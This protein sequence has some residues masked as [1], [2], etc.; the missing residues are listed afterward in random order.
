VVDGPRLYV[1]IADD[2]GLLV[3]DGEEG[4]SAWVTE[5]ELARRIDVLVAAGGSVLLSQ[6]R[7]S[8]AATPILV[9][10][11]AAGARIVEAS[12]PHPDTRR[13]DGV[14]ALMASAYVGAAELVDDVLRRG[15]DLEARDASGYTALMY[16]TNGGREAIVRALLDAGADVDAPD[17]RGS[18]PL[19][20][21]AQLGSTRVVEWLLGRGADAGARR[22]ADGLTALDVAERNGHDRAAAIL[23]S[24]T[25][26][27]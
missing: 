5:A 26:S 24:V 12:A 27:T 4:R 1:H 11:E 6:E 18:T 9:S 10:L 14:T 7:G 19:M 22:I 25:G 2:G 16:A 23:R 17:R 3:I 20:F 8:A 13:Q 15:A 21:A